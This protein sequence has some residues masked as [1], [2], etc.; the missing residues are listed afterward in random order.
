MSFAASQHWPPLLMG[1]PKTGC[2][3]HESLISWCLRGR[4]GSVGCSPIAVGGRHY[5]FK[6]NPSAGRADVRL[7]G[8]LFGFG[9]GA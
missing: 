5:R 9:R 6:I 3:R 7:W 4:Q 2:P 8:G 1:R